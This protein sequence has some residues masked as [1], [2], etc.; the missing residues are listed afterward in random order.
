MDQSNYSY[1]KHRIKKAIN[2]KLISFKDIKCKFCFLYIFACIIIKLC[3]IIALLYN[4]IKTSV[5]I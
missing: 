5:P 4:Q 1:S 3:D 2:F